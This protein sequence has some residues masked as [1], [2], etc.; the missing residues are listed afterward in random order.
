MQIKMMP[1]H[2]CEKGLT[3]KKKKKPVLESVEEKESLCTIA[4]MANWCRAG[5]TA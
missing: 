2:T 4:G 5:E 3:L 1:P